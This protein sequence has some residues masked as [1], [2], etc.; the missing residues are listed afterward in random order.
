MSTTLTLNRRVADR[1]VDSSDTYK[2]LFMRMAALQL[3]P[4]EVRRIEPDVFGALA[5]ACAHCESKDRCEQ[6][7]TA[8][9]GVRHAW[10]NYCCN[11]ATLRALAT[12]PWFGKAG[13]MSTG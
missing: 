11:T 2:L 5:G 7:L 8:A 10:V 12:L 4:D 6:D 1:I 9:G 3:E 13:K